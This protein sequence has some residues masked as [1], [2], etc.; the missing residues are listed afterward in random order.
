MALSTS[1]ALTPNGNAEETPY[2]M[3]MEQMQFVLD[4]EDLIAQGKA[5][6]IASKIEAEW[7]QFTKSADGQ[8]IDIKKKLYDPQNPIQQRLKLQ[9][10]LKALADQVSQKVQKAEVRATSRLSLLIALLPENQFLLFKESL[11][12]LVPQ[13]P[14]L[15]IS[16]KQEPSLEQELTLEQVKL[17]VNRPGTK[18]QL[19]SERPQ[20]QPVKKYVELEGNPCSEPPQKQ[21]LKKCYEPTQIPL[22]YLAELQ[23]FLKQ[24]KNPVEILTRADLFLQYITQRLIKHLPPQEG[25]IFDIICANPKKYEEFIIKIIEFFK[26][27]KQ[28]TDPLEMNNAYERFANP[29]GV[30]IAYIVISPTNRSESK[31]QANGTGIDAVNQKLCS[32]IRDEL[33]INMSGTPKNDSKKMPSDR[34]TS[35]PIGLQAHGVLRKPQSNG[36][37]A[38]KPTSLSRP[39]QTSNKHFP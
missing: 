36:K 7:K 27:L 31:H 14:L 1:Q 5:P 2:S 17:V 33:S 28:E 24:C 37:P 11:N 15:S 18:S 16:P 35:K 34:N 38:G 6:E 4:R 30:D 9:G 39:D 25:N 21:P 13:Q 19:G 20:K 3:R 29:L 32:I 12:A 8:Y 22:E 10:E 23:A 26:I